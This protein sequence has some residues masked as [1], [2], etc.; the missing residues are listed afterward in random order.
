MSAELVSYDL[1]KRGR[2]DAADEVVRVASL[3]VMLGGRKQRK[4]LVKAVGVFWRARDVFI[5]AGRDSL[6]SGRCG[7][8]K[9]V[10]TLGDA[11][12]AW[13]V[14][15]HVHALTC[16]GGGGPGDHVA[17]LR[18]ARENDDVVV[19]Y[20]PECGFEQHLTDATPL[21]SM[22]RIARRRDGRLQSL[23]R[24]H[25]RRE[26]VPALG[27]GEGN[28]GRRAVE[29]MPAQA[30][31]PIAQ[32]PL[33]QALPAA[34][35]RVDIGRQRGGGFCGRVARSD[36]RV[37]VLCEP[38]HICREPCGRRRDGFTLE[39]LPRVLDEGR[40]EPA[41]RGDLALGTHHGLD[42][43]QAV[44]GGLLGRRERRLSRSQFTAALVEER[45]LARL[46]RAHASPLGARVQPVGGNSNGGEVSNGVDET[47][48]RPPARE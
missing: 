43:G 22:A 41:Q 8:G 17:E 39:L 7:E 30:Q 29:I 24:G 13:Q 6:G 2:D 10:S 9:R 33:P 21:G 31:H 45:P 18:V 36:D 35:F 12:R 16:S 15:P 23:H 37:S 47:N 11:F 14:D 46:L 5:E 38:R 32:E 28:S 1:A 48:S 25:D 4:Q 3:Y 20:C 26:V 27:E 40:D 44:A 42:V 19:L 34:R